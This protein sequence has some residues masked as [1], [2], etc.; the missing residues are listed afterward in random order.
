MD[1][2]LLYFEDCPH[3]R[4]TDSHLRTIAAERP[5]LHIERHL[6]ETAE[7]AEQVGFRGSPTVLVDGVDPFADPGAAVGLM[8]RIYETPHGPAGS[9]TLT[10]LRAVL[11]GG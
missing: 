6:V 10:Q 3:W 1:V 2:T 9:P 4:V 8:C 7:E 5:A 11:S